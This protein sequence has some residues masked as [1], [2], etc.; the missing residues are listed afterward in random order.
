MMRNKSFADMCKEG[1]RKTFI[2]IGDLAVGNALG[3]DKKRGNTDP[4]PFT[5]DL[6]WLYEKPMPKRRNK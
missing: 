3:D 5:W 4:V 1:G 2:K 6:L